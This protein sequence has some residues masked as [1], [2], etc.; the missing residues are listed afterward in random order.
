M[1]LVSLPDFG[2]EADMGMAFDLRPGG[3]PVDVAG[4]HQ[5][6]FAVDA[7]GIGHVQVRGMR[8]QQRQRLL[9][10][11]AEVEAGHLQVRQVQAQAQVMLAS[12]RGQLFGHHEDVLVTLATEMPGERRHVLRDQLGAGEVDL[13]AGLMETVI[14]LGTHRQRTRLIGGETTD[15]GDDQPRIGVRE[16]LADLQGRIHH[17]LQIVDGAL[18]IGRIVR[19]QVQQLAVLEQFRGM[20][21]QP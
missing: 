20:H 10:V 7:L 1:V 2:D 17:P 6:A 11:E 5:Y 19:S 16:E 3:R 15:I 4:A 9:E 21:H 18:A 13:T 12:L 8:Q 14:E